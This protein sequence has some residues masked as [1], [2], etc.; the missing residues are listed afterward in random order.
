MVG[1]GLKQA[2]WYRNTTIGTKSDNKKEVAALDSDHY[3]Q[4]AKTTET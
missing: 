2:D 4:V 1:I 3:R